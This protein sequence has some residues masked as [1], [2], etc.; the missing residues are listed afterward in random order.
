[1]RAGARLLRRGSSAAGSSATT[2]GRSRRRSTPFRARLAANPDD[3]FARLYA[4]AAW[5]RRFPLSD[6]A[7]TALDGARAA[8]PGA[9]V[10]AARA[11]LG[12]AIAQA[13][14]ELTAHRAQFLPILHARERALRAGALSRA[15]L[16]DLITLLAET[17]PARVERAR[18]LLDARVATAPDAGL[19][20][21]YRAEVLRG[22]D[23]PAAL[24]ARYRAAAAAFCSASEASSVNECR[25]RARLRLEQLET[26]AAQRE[27]G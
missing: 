24:A 3:F 25:H 7:V 26:A 1:M 22:R 8:L 19:D 6:D 11:A 10:G 12:E 14:A 20:S 9:D 18:A 5:Q 13:L 2:R 17:G 21:F 27:G 16:I 23:S 4:A 15:E